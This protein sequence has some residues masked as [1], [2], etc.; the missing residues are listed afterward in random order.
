MIAGFLLALALSLVSTIVLEIAFFL[1]VGKRN[2]KDL[3]LLVLVNLITNP[4]VVSSY[5]LV[6]LYTRWSP[7][8]MVAVLE[9]FA[10]LTEGFFY[11]KKGQSFRRP[12]LFSVAAN[13]FSFG[14]GVLVQYFV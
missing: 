14:I 9:L 7:V 1:M 5:W 12:Y 11:K 6:A 10:V 4:V 2:K 3:G 8:I 13:L